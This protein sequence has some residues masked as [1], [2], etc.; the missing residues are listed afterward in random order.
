MLQPNINAKQFK[1]VQYNSALQPSATTI[2]FT[3]E[4]CS[5]NAFVE[6]IVLNFVSA[7]TSASNITCSILDRGNGYTGQINGFNP[8]TFVNIG[9]STTLL[10]LQNLVV[11]SA[12]TQATVFVSES[13]QDSEGLGNIYVQLAKSSGTFNVSFTMT[14]I[15]RQEVTYQA[16]L[17][18]RNQIGSDRPFRVLSQSGTAAYSTTVALTDQTNSVAHYPN[19]RNNTDITTFSFPVTSTN[20][21]F[22]FGTPYQTKRWFLGFSSDNT[23]NINTV[24]FSYWTGTAFASFSTSQYFLGAQGPGTYK[25]AYDGTVIFS[26]ITSWLPYQMPNDPLS[27]YNTT[28]NN[29]FYSGSA[30]GVQQVITTNNTIQNPSMYWIQCQ[31]GFATTSTLNVATIVPLIDPAFPLTTRRRLI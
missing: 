30:F 17:D 20:P 11:N 27:I 19:S 26:G 4:N 10:S 22:Y 6:Q 21:T 7:D 14:V 1:E 5:V 28:V 29:L 2:N 16:K 18:T 13:V 3:I 25:F 12:N 9:Y 15:F 24:T 23:P 8:V 31:V